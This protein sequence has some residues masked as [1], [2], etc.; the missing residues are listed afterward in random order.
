MHA[1]TDDDLDDAPENDEDIAKKRHAAAAVAM[2]QE[3]VW[4]EIFRVFDAD[5]G[6]SITREELK[7]EI[8]KMA[9]SG[10]SSVLVMEVSFVV[11]LE[12]SRVFLFI[13]Q[14][15][16]EADLDYMVGELD[17]NQDDDISFD[18]FFAYSQ[19]IMSSVTAVC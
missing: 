15:I 10:V 6:G 13:P 17:E 18:E 9:P 2:R 16:T 8:E 7:E 4:N 14:S 3:R 5:G 19:Y 12:L 11:F 1:Y